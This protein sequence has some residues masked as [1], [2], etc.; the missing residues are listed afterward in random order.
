MNATHV[1]DSLTGPG[2]PFEI[3]EEIV[4]GERMPVFKNRPRS[5]RELL[6]DSARHGDL[7]YVVI[8]DQRLSYDEHL[9]RVAAF[10]QVLRDEF[11]VAPG[12]RVAILAANSAEWIIAF[13]ATLSIGGVVASMNSMWAAPEIEHA[14]DSCEPTVLIADRERL[15]RVPAPGGQVS[16]RTIEV[17]S[18]FDSLVARGRGAAVSDVPIDEDDPAVILYTS[19]T[20]GRSKGAVAS[21]R[22]ICGFVTL[23]KYSGA[24]ALAAANASGAGPAPAVGTRQIALITVPLFH[25]SGLYGF[26]VGQLATG[27]T[28]V[29]RSGRFD[30]DDVLRL[31]EA[32]GVTMWAALG[33]MGPRVAERADGCG[34][35]LS[36]MRL[37]AV[38]GAPVS[39]AHQQQ[40][41]AAFP[42]ASINISMGYTSS[43]AVAVVTRIQGQ[44]MRDH[45]TSAGRVMATTSLEI[46]GADGRPVADGIDGEIHVRSP[47]LMTEYWRDDEAT[48]TALKPGRWLAMGDIGCL[49]DGRLYINSRARDM[50]LVN[51]ENVFP[52]EVEYRLD[53][54][55]DVRESAVVGVDHPTTGQ[56]IRAV[57]VVSE[58]A[59]L[60]AEVLKAWC[61]DALAAYKVPTQ[62]EIRHEAL[63]RNAS[64][65]VLKRELEQSSEQPE[66]DET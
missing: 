55:P 38:G 57:V 3:T 14:L 22:S 17:E 16:Y 37:L 28:V 43:E 8:G 12:D 53:A 18:E 6:V 63:P 29:L 1:S 47:Y 32:E 30:E 7:C 9:Q 64:G 42:N 45:P 51:A 59:Q 24:A 56:A 52:T 44:E 39:P 5:A 19:G 60:T 13:W 50:I 46:R 27:G 2:A 49:R 66:P 10:A 34:R 20:T 65:K 58:S 62:W 54:H 48:R 15:A 25:A 35:D 40:L 33:S 11:G 4:L 61:R 36:S 23:S 31:I 41:R 26:V 21:H